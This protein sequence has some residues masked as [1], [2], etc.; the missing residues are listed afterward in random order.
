MSSIGER[1]VNVSLWRIETEG[2]CIDPFTLSD[3]E[4]NLANELDQDS[5]VDDNDIEIM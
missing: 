5:E 4:D 3:I 1:T 2:E